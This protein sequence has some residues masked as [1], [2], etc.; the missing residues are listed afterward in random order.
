MNSG[1]VDPFKNCVDGKLTADRYNPIVRGVSGR[2][3]IGTA[4]V[5][6][7]EVTNNSPYDI[8]V[9]LLNLQSDGSVKLKFPR[10]IDDE[11]NGV[12]IPKNGGKR[13]V[14][15]D[16][17]RVEADGKFQTGAF[18]TSR[19]PEIDAFKLLLTTR[20]MTW[21]DLSYLEMDS[22]RRNENASLATINEWIAVDVVF[23]VGDQVKE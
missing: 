23:E 4:E 16:Q 5:F 17:C 2:Y 18:R 3:P 6:W 15:S 21:E 11:K 12:L 1:P 19:Q 7:F 14:N 13:I 22:L 8:Y 9:A 20:P 10:N